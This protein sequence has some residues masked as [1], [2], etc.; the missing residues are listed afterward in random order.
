MRPTRLLVVL[1][2]VAGWACAPCEPVL[3]QVGGPGPDANAAHSRPTAP[4]NTIREVFKALEAC[5]IPPDLDESRAG[6][7]ITVMLSFKRDGEL[8]GEPRITYETREA[9]AEERM[10]YRIAV[11]QA[12]A[13]CTPLP[14]TEALGNAL[15]G[16]PM[17][18]RFIDNRK[19]KQAG[20]PDGRQS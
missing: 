20:A 10:I 1:A 3:A 17:T 14:F 9:S 4:L 8:L 2:A 7:Q 5:W 19:L 18:M 16:R 6:M 12:L 13:R 11:A 15:A